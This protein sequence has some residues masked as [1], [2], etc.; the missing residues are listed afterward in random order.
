[1]QASE[2]DFRVALVKDA[3]SQVTDSALS[4]LAGIGVEILDTTALEER[5]AEDVQSD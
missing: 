2:R 1:M 3:V 5:L 4:E